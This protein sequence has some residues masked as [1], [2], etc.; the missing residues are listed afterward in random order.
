[1]FWGARGWALKESLR[2]A[3]ETPHLAQH[4]NE[5]SFCMYYYVQ[6]YPVLVVGL[7]VQ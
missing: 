3:A 5:L 2:C 7:V 4:N 1:M 6:D